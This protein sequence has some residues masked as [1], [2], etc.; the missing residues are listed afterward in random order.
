M[1]LRP[2]PVSPSWRS[3]RTAALLVGAAT[4]ACAALDRHVSITSQAMVYLVAVVIVAYACDR[5]TAVATAV[6]AVI[7]LNFFFV[8]P[9]YTLAVENR[10]HLIALA[11]ML[12]VTLLVS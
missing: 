7:A 3:A 11:A 12:G 9:R 2:H 5:L 6:T 8:P 4:A 1:S 10:E